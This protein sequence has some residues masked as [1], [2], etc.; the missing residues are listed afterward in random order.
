MKAGKLQRPNS[1]FCF[2]ACHV[3]L[4]VHTKSVS[5]RILQIAHFFSSFMYDRKTIY[6]KFWKKCSAKLCLV[7]TAQL[8]T[9]VH[10]E[11]P[12]ESA[13]SRCTWQR[14]MHSEDGVTSGSERL[15]KPGKD[16]DF[17]RQINDDKIYTCKKH[18]RP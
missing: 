14:M 1:L 15:R 10:V 8:M 3:I 13:F 4:M 16:K 2:C 5:S 12:E 17:R 9:A 18:F 7:S 6:S 11:G